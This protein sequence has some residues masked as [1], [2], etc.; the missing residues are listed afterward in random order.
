VAHW[1]GDILFV[2]NFDSVGIDA[3]KDSH[4]P[5][6][7]RK[8]RKI[9]KTNHMPQKVQWP[10]T[11]CAWLGLWQQQLTS[12]CSGTLGNSFVLFCF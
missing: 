3:Q 9:T 6:R 12:I 1:L 11:A 8:N 5:G 2:R 4:H 10:L 7:G